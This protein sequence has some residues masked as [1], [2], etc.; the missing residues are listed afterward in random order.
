[1]QSIFNSIQAVKQISLLKNEF[2]FH[3]GDSIKNF[4]LFK[5]YRIC[6]SRVT[7]DGFIQ[8]ATDKKGCFS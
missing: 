1:M 6:M 3:A 8:A 5:S 7:L 2:L 4:Y